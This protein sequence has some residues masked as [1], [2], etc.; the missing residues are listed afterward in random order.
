MARGR[1]PPGSQPEPR[2]SQGPR[3]PR[4]TTTTTDGP[5]TVRLTMTAGTVRVA[6]WGPGAERV[7]G[8][9]ANTDLFKIMLAAYGWT[10]TA[11][12]AGD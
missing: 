4:R 10:E 6:A 5:A 2:G 9:I 12:T 8:F 7:H 3:G 1:P 11:K